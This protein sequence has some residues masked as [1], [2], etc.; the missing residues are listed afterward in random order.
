[1][2]VATAPLHLATDQTH[3]IEPHAYVVKNLLLPNAVGQGLPLDPHWFQRFDVDTVEGDAACQ[4][5]ATLRRD[6]A[7]CDDGVEHFVKLWSPGFRPQFPVHQSPQS[8][9]H[10]GYVYMLLPIPGMIN[11]REFL[12]IPA[13]KIIYETHYWE[14]TIPGNST[15]NS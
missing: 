15:A 8:G 12:Q 5:V 10:Y 7:C 13:I 9:C 6:P 4:S 2:P 1:M 11:Y 14:C 3:R